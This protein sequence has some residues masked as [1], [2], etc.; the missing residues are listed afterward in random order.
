VEETVLEAR[1]NN[2]RSFLKGTLNS[3]LELMAE[4][5]QTLDAKKCEVRG[6]TSYV[7]VCV[8]VCVC[9]RV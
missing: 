4:S 1:L 3:A 9:V 5:V 8:C 6:G 7:C 2:S